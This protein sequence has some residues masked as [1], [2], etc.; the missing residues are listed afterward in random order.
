M[1]HSL[2]QNYVQ[3]VELAATEEKGG[4]KSASATISGQGVYGHLKFESGIH[5]VQRV[6][7][8][9]TSG[10]MHTSAVSVAVLP[11]AEEVPPGPKTLLG[12]L[13]V[14]DFVARSCCLNPTVH[15]EP[16]S[17]CQAPDESNVLA[18]CPAL[19]CANAQLAN[20]HAWEQKHPHSEA[21]LYCLCTQ[22]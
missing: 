10:R 7:V 20:L 9:E 19:Y 18:A 14:A 8:T 15:I 3:I 6:P 16:V 2:S 5:R 4:C 22:V 21:S 12:W 11:Q 13:F 1:L 17:A